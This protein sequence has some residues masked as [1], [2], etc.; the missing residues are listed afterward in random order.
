MADNDSDQV[1]NSSWHHNLPFHEH[2]LYASDRALVLS[3]NTSIKCK[4]DFVDE[5]YKCELGFAVPN[6]NFDYM[7]F[8]GEGANERE[9]FYD[10][11]DKWKLRKI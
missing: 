6:T 5:N 7:F 2:S 4:Y 3:A 9:A 10:A 8:Y 11:Y 1:K